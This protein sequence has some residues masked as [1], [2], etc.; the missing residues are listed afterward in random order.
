MPISSTDHFEK[1]TD[2]CRCIPM[3]KLYG[4]FKAYNYDTIVKLKKRDERK[5][6][7]YTVSPLHR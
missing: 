4:K 1:S 5:M 6:E 7:W 2:Y 3:L